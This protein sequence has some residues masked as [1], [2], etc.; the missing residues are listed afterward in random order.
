MIGVPRRATM[1]NAIFVSLNKTYSQL[2]TAAQNDPSS[3]ALRDCTT[4]SWRLDAGTARDVE[5]LI[6]VEHTRVVSVYRVPVPSDRWMVVPPGAVDEGRK[7]IPTEAGDDA[8]FAEARAFPKV[9]LAG[10]VGYGEVA[11]DANGRLT[12]VRLPGS[13]SESP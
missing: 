2:T 8:R 4:N 7:I 10:P 6:G 13:G 1:D 11:I 5:W 12:A 3:E 9:H